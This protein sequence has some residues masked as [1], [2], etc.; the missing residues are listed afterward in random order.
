MATS[1]IRPGGRFEP[2]VD[3]HRDPAHVADLH[4]EN[5]EVGLGGAHRLAHVLAAG[6][7]DD[8]LPGRHTRGLRLVSHPLRVR[9]DHDRAHHPHA[10]SDREAA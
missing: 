8:L 10:T 6:H 3:R 2:E 1:G 5:R 4:V 7:F 9:C